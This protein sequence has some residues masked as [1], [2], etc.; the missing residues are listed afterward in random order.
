MAV[1]QAEV[2]QRVCETGQHQHRAR[3]PLAER[4]S[5]CEEF[6]GKLL[7]LV[8]SIAWEGNRGDGMAIHRTEFDATVIGKHEQHAPASIGAL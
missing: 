5:C 7:S 1:G 6:G 3:E 2:F 8:P 4:P